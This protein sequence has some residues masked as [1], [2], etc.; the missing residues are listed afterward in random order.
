MKAT[1]RPF[2]LSALVVAAVAWTQ[3]AAAQ[4][5]GRTVLVQATPDN[6]IGNC[7]RLRNVLAGINDATDR[8]PVIVKLEAGIY[9][10]VSTPV[11]MKPFVT[12][13]GAGRSFSRIL[14]NPLGIAKG[15][16]LGANDSALRHL[17]VEHAGSGMDELVVINTLGRRMSFTDIAVKIDSANA[18]GVSGIRADGGFLDFNSVSIHTNNPGGAGQGILAFSGARLNMMNVWIQNLS[19]AGNPAAL[20]LSDSSVT[21]HG[22]L[23]S[24]NFASMVAFGNSAIEL[25]GG[26]T[27]GAAVSGGGFTGSFSCIAIA[28]GVDFTARGAACN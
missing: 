1:N 17:T 9:N 20:A 28:N 21:G 11:A 13:E 19:G 16:I 23:F 8:N 7:N 14:G 24:S 6:K 2:A 5:F 15:V 18:F 4:T 10:C 3:P 26:T 12:I 22:I 25:V 27:I